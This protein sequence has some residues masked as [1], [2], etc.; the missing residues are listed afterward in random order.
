[1]SRGAEMRVEILIEEIR[2]LHDA[3]VA[4]DESVA[5]FPVLVLG[6]ACTSTAVW[7]RSSGRDLVS[8]LDPPE[9]AGPADAG[10]SRRSRPATRSRYRSGHKKMAGTKFRPSLNREAS[11]LGDVRVRRP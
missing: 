2:R 7:H 9:F 4:I 10:P 11:R 8:R 3:H 1:M 6:L 5:I